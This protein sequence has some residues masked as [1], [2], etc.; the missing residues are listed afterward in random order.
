MLQYKHFFIFKHQL[1]LY[2][3]NYNKLWRSFFAIGVI[4]IAVQQLICADFRPVIMPPG[5]PAWLSHRLVWTWVFSVAMIV[6]GATILFETKAKQASLILGTILLLFVVLFQIPGK[7]Y[8]K[9]IGAWT[10]A[11]KEFTFAG[12]AFIVAGTLTS[13]NSTSG[14]LE[15][16]EKLIPYGKYPLAITMVVFGSLHFIYVD[17]A[18]ALVPNWIPGH[19]FWTYFAGVALMLAG[20]AILLNIK[21]QL[22]AALLGLMIFLWFIMLHIPRAIADPH[23]GNGN[24]WTS[25]F[26]ALAFSG[27]TFLI[28]GKPINSTA[29][30]K[31]ETKE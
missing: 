21:T 20:V 10:D 8:P 28:A 6:A 26:E 29:E 2:M 12:G 11:F 15:Q 14:F 9:I 23:T 17:F 19:L 27:I 30:V 18:A 1:S 7:P 24:E 4:A 5:Y 31:S 16:L 3:E 25:V 22:A 13:A